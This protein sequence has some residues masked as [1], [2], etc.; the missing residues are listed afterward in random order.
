M[1]TINITSLDSGIHELELEG[2][3]VDVGLDEEVFGEVLVDVRLD[4]GEDRIFVSFTATSTAELECDR[5]LEKF[6]Q[7]LEGSFDLVFLPEDE[8]VGAGDDEN[9]RVL[10][11]ED[12]EIDIADAVR[13]TLL[14]AVPQRKV[15]PGADEIEIPTEFADH[16][17]S[18]DPRWEAL[19]KLRS[20]D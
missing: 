6:V 10:K 5:T 13:D 8:A 9:V 12:E 2:D 4:R 17:D 7:P 19:R 20:E 11:P 1:L 3:A 14:L 16:D 18:I 15:A